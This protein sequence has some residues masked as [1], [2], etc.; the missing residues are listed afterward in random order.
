VAF[1]RNVFVNC[2]FDKD[3][4]ILL[5]SI[6]FTVSYLGFEPRIASEN[7]DAGLPRLEKILTLIRDS[8]YAIHDISRLEADSAGALSRLNMAFE[9]GIDFG[10]RAYGGGRWCEKR[11]LILDAQ[12]FRYQAA[13]SDLAGSDVQ[14]HENNPEF[15]VREVRDW[16]SEYVSVSVLGAKDIWSAFGDF[17]KEAQIE[18]EREGHSIE[19][20]RRLRVHEFKR[21]MRRWMRSNRTRGRRFSGR[22][23]GGASATK[24]GSVAAGRDRSG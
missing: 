5:E 19:D 18:L 2:P 15:V 17:T 11:F 8:K 9:L 21:Y 24:V 4:R 3:Y 13:L 1:E 12:R 14:V 10:C 20:L 7:G 16:L 23:N 22:R 6:L